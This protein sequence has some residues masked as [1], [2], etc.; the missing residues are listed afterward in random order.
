MAGPSAPQ[1]QGG[2]KNTYYILWVMAL[3]VFVGGV[4][5]YFADYEL[6]VFFLAVRKY[7]LMSVAFVLDHLPLQYFSWVHEQQLRVDSDLALVKQITPDTLTLDMASVLSTEVGDFIRYPIGVLLAILGI[8]I[9]NAHLLM[10]YTRKHNMNTLMAQEVKNWPQ[11]NVV[12]K[13][14]LLEHDLDSGPWAMAMTPMQFSKKYQLVRIEF[15]EIVGSGFSKTQ[16]P[17]FKIVLDRAKAERVFSAQLGRTWQG[18]EALLPH[19]RAVFA[20]LA[21]RACRDSK[22]AANMVNQ[23]A[24]SAGE[25]KINLKGADEL[26]NKHFKSSAIQKLIKAHAY[27]FTIFASLLQ[28]AREDGVMASADFLWVKPIDR[29]LWYVLNN[30]GRQTPSAE[31]AGIF[32]HWYHELALRRPLSV[33][34]VGSAIDALALALA[35]VIYTPSDEERAE[36]IKRREEAQATSVVEEAEEKPADTKTEEAKTE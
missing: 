32:S 11:I 19:R 10:R 6:K 2:E 18:T 22:T 16:A 21:A 33:P 26:L 27:E 17:E 12:T 14:N 36:I 24:F 20:V 9:Y 23:L 15:A 7:E 5:W 35:D 8:Y 13:I 1:D 28:L 29:R 30:V 25:G 34:V 3:I 31:V 4:I